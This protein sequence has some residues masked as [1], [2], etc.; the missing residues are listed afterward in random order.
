MQWTLEVELGAFF[1][2]AGTNAA[3][4]SVNANGSAIDNC[5]NALDVR[6]AHCFRLDI[7][8]TH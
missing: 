7:R 2:S 3:G 5:F 6:L 1:D 4:A 8:V